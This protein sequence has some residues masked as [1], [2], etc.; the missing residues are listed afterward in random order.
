M[1]EAEVGSSIAAQ[2]ELVG[3]RELLWI[4]V[5]GSECDQHRYAGLDLGIAER[6]GLRG[7]TEGGGADG[8]IEPKQFIQC[9]WE[10]ARVLPQAVQ[11]G[12]VLEQR[13]EGVAEEVGSGLVSGDEQ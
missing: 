9:G 3:Q 4:S 12:R 7:E 13:Q 10:V 6:E 2:V 8:C 5:G 1:A 11:L